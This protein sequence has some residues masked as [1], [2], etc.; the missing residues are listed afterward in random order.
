MGRNVFA[1]GLEISAKASDNRSIAAMPDVCLS[2]PGP[3]SGPVPIAYPNSAFARDTTG[4]TRT[5]KIG[6]QEVG[7]KN[8]S[9]YRKSTGDEP[10]TRNFGMGVI[11]HNITG[12]M[13]FAAWSMDVKFE[14]ANVTRFMDLTTHNHTNGGG[15]AV[16]ENLGGAA[17]GYKEEDCKTLAKK[18]ED[19]RDEIEKKIKKK[20][21]KN[22]GIAYE[23]DD[24]EALNKAIKT[25]EKELEK[26]KEDTTITHALHNGKEIKACSDAS[27]AKYDP[28][29]VSGI[30]T[31]YIKEL[32]SKKN[33]TNPQIAQEARKIWKWLRPNKSGRGYKTNSLACRGI[34]NKKPILR[35][36][37]NTGNRPYQSH[38]EARIIDEIF[39]TGYGGTLLLCV[40]WPG[41][42]KAGLTRRSPCLPSCNPLIC[43][44]QAAGCLTIVLC[45]ESGNPVLPDCTDPKTDV[46]P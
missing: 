11:S 26:L 6:G 45:D 9:K 44:V 15:G 42:K 43:A 32:E 46:F 33:S 10:A 24:E 2:P 35:Y 14:G 39:K 16:G 40:D 7:K 5:V 13:K 27:L 1:N 20:K 12:P 25:E 36:K 30:T 29:F 37:K 3:P 34:K 28:K 22:E 38:T 18:N 8:I 31:D 19:A 23:N 4:G 21:R 41:G 17:H